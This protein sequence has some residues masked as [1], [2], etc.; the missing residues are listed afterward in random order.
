MKILMVNKFLY[1]NGG[2][3]TYIFKLGDYLKA[4][5][6]EVEYFG[7]EHENR[8]VGNSSNSYTSN[9]NFH[10]NKLKKI[11]Y[12]I[13]II[14][15][16]EARKKI[17]V[18]LENFKPEVVHLNNFNFQLTPSIIYEIRKYEKQS[19]TK[20]K[21]VFTAHDS[22]LVCPNHL[23]LNPISNEKC[24]KCLEGSYINCIKG[25]CIHGSV[26]KSII[27]TIE[28]TLWSTTRIYKNIDVIISPS[29]FLNEKLSMNK[30][31]Q[32]RIITLHNFVDG[33][34]K[35][36]N[37][38]EKYIA[39]FGR[40]SKE[41]GIETLLKVCK[42]LKDIQFVFAGNG[43]LEGQVNS[44]KNITNMGFLSEKELKKV[45]SQAQFTIIASE[46][47][48][49]CPFSVME[50]QIYG[51]PVLGANIGGIPELI[52]KDNTGELFE[53]GNEIELKNKILKL[54]NDKSLIDKYSKNCKKIKFDTIE[55]YYKKIIKIYK[56]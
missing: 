9:M 50:S 5:G 56:E 2:S 41:K 3:E 46:C 12:P 40:Y 43:P 44:V 4:Q 52:N 8:I 51:T 45:I 1:P 38:K 6:H 47:F 28:A 39:Y 32:G 22:Q 30:D 24:T 25:R 21:I 18:V 35:N 15:S 7:M 34:N 17:R 19:K 31:L 16:T 20:I 53:S 29:K 54:W 23:M 33:N 27:A 13:R 37:K 10:T 55:D 48:E 11:T 49:N 26:A 42:E 14:Y 36:I